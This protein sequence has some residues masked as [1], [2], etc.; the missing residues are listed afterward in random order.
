M[1]DIAWWV[2]GGV[3]DPAERLLI[4][5]CDSQWNDTPPF[6]EWTVRGPWGEIHWILTKSILDYN[7]GLSLKRSRHN[8]SFQ[9]WIN[10]HLHDLKFPHW[11][12]G[13]FRH[14]WTFL[15]SRKKPVA[16]RLKRELYSA[17]FFNAWTKV[18]SGCLR[19]VC[20]IS[21][22][23]FSLIALTVCYPGSQHGSVGQ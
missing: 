7:R 22:L 13:A 5:E 10:D 2:K 1:L 3:C 18:V 12:H 21:P 20:A 14:T 8:A 6:T 15:S 9:S 16:F 17:P 23:S 4:F 19:N 11:N